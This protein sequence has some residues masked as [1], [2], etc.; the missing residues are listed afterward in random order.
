[1]VGIAEQRSKRARVEGR[2][3]GPLGRFVPSPVLAFVNLLPTLPLHRTTAVFITAMAARPAQAIDH[4]ESVTG[5]RFVDEKL[6]AQALDTTGLATPQANRRLALLGDM[7]LRAVIVD[8]WFPT[9]AATGRPLLRLPSR[10]VHSLTFTYLRCRGQPLADHCR[11]YKSSPRWE[12]MRSRCPYYH[13]SRPS[14]SNQQQNS[15]YDGRSHPRPH[16][17]G[18]RQRPHGG[19]ECYGKIWS[20]DLIPKGHWR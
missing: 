7:V 3:L 6:L 8:E 10:E 20:H 13:E 2:R 4:I 19:Q 15:G 12:R 14:G 5:H 9:G 16:L 18:L 17:S 11:E 1:M